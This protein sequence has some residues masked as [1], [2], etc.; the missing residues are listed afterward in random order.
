MFKEQETGLPVLSTVHFKNGGLYRGEMCDN[1]YNGQGHFDYE[2][3]NRYVC[4][5]G[6]WKNGK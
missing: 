5:S 6:Q 3:H 4:Y 1:M 2:N